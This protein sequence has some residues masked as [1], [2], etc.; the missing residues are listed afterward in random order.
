M[1]RGRRSPYVFETIPKALISEY[2]DKGWEKATK[3]NKKS[4]RMRKPKSHDVALEDRTWAMLAKLG[5]D[6]MNKDRQFR[7]RHAK[8]DTIPGKQ[9]DV[10]VADRETALVVE[11][12]SAVARRSRSFQ[13]GIHE[14]DAIRRKV[15]A[16]LQTAL[17][18]KRKMAWLFVTSNI[19]VG[20]ADQK[21][22]VEN[23]VFHFSEDDLSYYEQL[24]DHLGPVA[25]YQLFARV[26]KG[27]AIPG[28]DTRVPALRG[29]AGGRTV[30]SF[31]VE[32]E[33]LLKIG[34]V[35]HRTT[36]S[37][38]DLNTYQRLLKKPRLTSIKNYIEKGGFFP[39]SVILNLRSASALQFDL[40][41]GGGH[42]SKTDLGVLHLPKKYQTA[43][44]IDGQHRLFGYGLTEQ[45]RTDMI[46]VVAFS[47]LPVD[48]QSD[49]FVKINNEQKSVPINLLMSLEAEFHEDSDDPAAALKSALTKLVARMNDKNDSLLYKRILLGEET[50]TDRRSIT[51]R[52]LLGQGLRRTHV[53]GT[54]EKG[55]FVQGYCWNA[56]YKKS[57]HK[58][59]SFLNLCFD[60]IAIADVDQWERGAQDGLATTNVGFSA[61]VVV[62]DDIVMH[63]VS[64]SGLKPQQLTAESLYDAITP[65]LESVGEFLA[66]LNAESRKKLRKIGGGSGTQDI[67]REY[68]KAINDR[69][70]EF[71][72][73]GLEQWKEESS[74]K[75]NDKSRPLVDKIHRVIM[76]H[77]RSEMERSYGS[78]L[79]WSKVPK[80]IQKH[81][82]DREIEENYSEPRENFMDLIHYK[83]VIEE[84]KDIFPIDLFTPPGM[85]QAAKPTKLKWLVDL[86]GVR[87]K[88]S[89]PERTAVTEGEYDRVVETHA[90]L[91]PRLVLDDSTPSLRSAG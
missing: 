34:Y 91:I 60:T 20:H 85:T 14:I 82:A 68:Q 44:I 61:L 72:P 79:W 23:N 47:N 32:P 4:Q 15:Y 70:N 74:G 86:N 22:F 56:T 12:K 6:W 52:Y 87:K 49:M 55:A 53:I 11:C 62:I 45:R 38:D 24:V 89:H 75:F 37:S 39:N 18:G 83:Y 25:K 30:Y 42:A 40:A 69:F 8:D 78:K 43:M 7:V 50:R 48:Q 9:I 17:G 36:A 64:H 3:P 19:I 46:P 35:L 67:V 76:L 57:V 29:K 26:F 51:L 10:F 16:T 63:V 13:L 77:V 80:K 5:W 41:G 90:W 66:S 84:A 65:Y 33:L 31:L 58:A 81:C 59:Y 27:K 73:D 21:R 54:I 1:L 88:L 71:A 28:L 2:E